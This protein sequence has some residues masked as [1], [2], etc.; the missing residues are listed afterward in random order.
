MHRH[1]R[2]ASR[3]EKVAGLKVRSILPVHQ[4]GGDK[5]CNR[6]QDKQSKTPNVPR[7]PPHALLIQTKGQPTRLVQHYHTLKKGQTPR[8]GR[9]TRPKHPSFSRDVGA[10]NHEL[11]PVSLVSQFTVVATS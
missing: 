7:G 10:T 1:S 2:P 3:S 4:I 9:E 5:Q 8:R 6:W 11:M